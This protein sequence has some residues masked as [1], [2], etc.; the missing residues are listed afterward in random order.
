MEKIIWYSPEVK[1]P[2][3]QQKVV[4]RTSLGK[5]FVGLFIE[6]EDMFFVGFEEQGDF[7]F[8]REVEFWKDY[9]DM[10]EPKGV[11]LVNVSVDGESLMLQFPTQKEQ[12]Q[13]VKKMK[14]RVENIIYALDPC[15]LISLKQSKQFQK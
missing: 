12:L 1:K 13:F 7:L 9:C 3:D 5:E 4:F 14:N 2:F 6:K 15:E 10:P 8:S 11:W